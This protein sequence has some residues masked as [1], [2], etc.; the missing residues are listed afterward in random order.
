MANNAFF[1]FFQD[2]VL[3]GAWKKLTPSARTLYPVLAIHTD[4]D[5]KPVFPSLKRLK[6]LSGLGNSGLASALQSLK[7]NG[8]IRIWSGKHKD[9]NVPNHYQF[10]FEYPNCQI[11][12]APQQDKATPVAGIGYAPR[13][14]KATPDPSQTLVPAEDKLTPQQ[15]TNKRKGT[16]DIPTRTTTTTIQG[17]VHINIDH[18][19]NDAVVDA[20]KPFFSETIARQLA[21]EHPPEYIKEK[22]EITRYNQERGKVRDPAAFLREAL[23][24]DYR[25][26][27]GFST[28]DERAAAEAHERQ[29]HELM[30]RIRDGAIT[31]ARHRTLGQVHFVD[32]PTDLSFVILQ[33]KRGRSRCVNSWDEIQQYEFE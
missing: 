8:L 30:E 31:T 10:V 15:G 13:W 23:S 14:D 33:D 9:G 29:L 22:I 19:S 28:S 20:L 16:R 27:S 24:Q 32:V 12:L 3:S 21:S 17:D 18:R 25:K 1:K 7:E 26:P 11:S 6:K 5:F 4:K 2:L